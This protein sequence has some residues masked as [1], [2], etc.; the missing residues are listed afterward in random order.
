MRYSYII[1]I[2][3]ISAARVVAQTA[4][5]EQGYLKTMHLDEIQIYV[6]KD[7]AA[8]H[9]IH[10]QQ[11][12]AVEQILEKNSSINLVRRGNFAMEPMINGMSGG[13]INLTIDGMKLFGACTDRMDPVSAYVETVNMEKLEVTTGAEG[14]KHGS[15]VG[16]SVNLRLKQPEMRVNKS[17]K[18]AAGLN[19][20]SIS[21][22]YN[23]FYN[24]DYSSNNLGLR[25]SGVYR[26]HG[27]YKDGHHQEVNFSQYEKMNHALNGN[28]RL[29]ED[30]KLIF[31]F[32]WDDAWDI[33]YP[34]LPMDV[35]FAKARIYK[36]GFEQENLSEQWKKLNIMA[37]G[38]NITHEMD[39][40]QRDVIIRMDMPGW[41]NTYGLNMDTDWK[42][43]SHFLKARTEFFRN[44]VRAEMTMYPNEGVS[45]FMLTW[46]DAVRTAGGL[47]LQDRIPFGR[48]IWS[49][50]LRVDVA[51][52][53]IKSKIGM[54]QLEVLD[55]EYDGSD[56]RT[57]LNFSSTLMVPAG[58]YW[59]AEFTGAYAE[60]FPT[61]T[62][63]FG[64]FLFNSQDGYDYVGDPSLD[65]EKAWQFTSGLYLK[66][67]G[68][69]V[70]FKAFGYY[71]KGYIV[72]RVD[73]TIDAMTLGARGVKVYENLSHAWV[74]G[75]NSDWTVKVTD[76]I[77]Y[78]G[79][80][81]YTLG[82]LK[83]GDKLPMLVPLGL[84]NVLMYKYKTF[85]AEVGYEFVDGRD[86]ENKWSGEM[87]SDDYHVFNAKVVYQQLLGEY[88]IKWQLGIDNIFDVAY[89]HPLDWGGILR[90]GRSVNIGVS[91][92]F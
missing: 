47:F 37:Y 51:H 21:Q 50:S 38:N 26:H 42:L 39:D 2:I 53:E 81:E 13:Q 43:G 31:G 59:Q 15:T 25:Y 88:A 6:G 75:L 12:V 11:F 18:G 92:H 49:N 45:M 28:Y 73:E 54:A 46:P 20:Q 76:N 62:E 19:Y 33:G 83:G 68:F 91:C 32:I 72:G 44:D 67:D 61:V 34:A 41:S 87:P 30:K 86:Q 82:E 71:F 14:S 70:N 16:G 29:A 23:A 57:A 10:D 84:T 89:R 9:A 56:V 58:Q 7:T 27:I 48:W 74:T 65:N 22:G 52:N 36:L 64:F 60:R 3:L 40:S 5:Q 1:L 35:A 79:V 90:P 78:N 55:Y 80:A 77:V 63:Q 24:L 8:D 69:Q 17:L 66:K 4:E 85:G